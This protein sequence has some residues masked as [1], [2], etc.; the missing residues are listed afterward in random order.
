MGYY[1]V[2]G[3]C[4]K[5]PVNP[6]AGEKTGNP[7]QDVTIALMFIR[8]ERGAVR[9][10]IINPSSLPPELL[11]NNIL[12][13]A[14][15]IRRLAKTDPVLLP[16]ADAGYSD[17]EIFED[18]IL[19]II[20]YLFLNPAPIPGFLS[21]QWLCDYGTE[22]VKAADVARKIYLLRTERDGQEPGFFSGFDLP[23]ECRSECVQTISRPLS[24]QEVLDAKGAAWIA[25]DE[26]EYLSEG[27]KS[28]PG[29][30]FLADELT[31]TTFIIEDHDQIVLGLGISLIEASV[32]LQAVPE[33]L[34]FITGKF[35]PEEMGMVSLGSL[36]KSYLHNG[37]HLP[38]TVGKATLA[39]FAK[40]GKL[41]RQPLEL[42]AEGVCRYWSA[43]GYIPAFVMISKH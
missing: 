38:G 26:S 14:P 36:L 33:F 32:M 31:E 27:F 21:Q 10:H 40:D 28:L 1:I 42:V 41:T 18:K 30:K 23:E 2:D 22:P 19:I 8:S 29:S 24:L 37:W 25:F 9:V 17:V 20:T 39:L 6:D 4:K 43:S 7:A 16:L 5:V 13:T 11:Y 35:P 34:R 3:I 12:L 15:Y